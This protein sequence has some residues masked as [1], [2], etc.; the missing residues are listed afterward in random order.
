MPA[1]RAHGC[2][3]DLGHRVRSASHRGVARSQLQPI[4]L[5]RPQGSWMAMGALD[6]VMEN[7]GDGEWPMATNG[8]SMLS[9][10]GG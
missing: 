6:N 8:L 5:S 7:V 1:A 9:D 10:D 4:L 2:S 3:L